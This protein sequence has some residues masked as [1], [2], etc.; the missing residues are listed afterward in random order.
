MDS[1]TGNLPGGGA[2][3][4]LA[5]AVTGRR[6]WSIAL[7]VLV[8]AV[9]IMALV[10][11][12]D[13]AGEAPSALPESAES[14]QVQQRL[15]EFPQSETASAVLVGSRS[16]GAELTSA[17]LTEFD[18]VHTRMLAV[19]E[20]DDGAP[21]PAMV[22]SPDGK[23]V[24]GPVPV[25]AELSGFA[26]SDQVSALR[27]AAST[28]LPDELRAEVTGG[29][30]FGADI[31]DSF[32]GA[33]TTLL[34]VTALVVAA[35]LV[36]TY[37]S[38]ILWLVPLAVI[39]FAD[40]FAGTV[41]TA[42]AEIT[43][44]S[45][46]GSTSGITSVL[47]F[48]AGTNYA[49]LLISRYRQELRSE[50][51]HRLALRHA[52]RQAG[53]TILA[54]NGT[55]VL[56]LLTLLLTSIPSTR[57][58]GALAAAGLLVA[59]VFVLLV[60]PPALALCGKKLFWPF[61]PKVGDPDT[62]SGGTWF[63]VASTVARHPWRTS[64]TA[65]AALG[66]CATG[67]LGIQVG[68]SQTEQF[69]VTAE[70]VDGLDTLAAHFPSGLSNPTTVLVDTGAAQ[71]TASV[72][73]ATPGVSSVTE[74]GRSDTGL[75]RFTVVLDAPPA[76]DEAFATIETIRETLPPPGGTEALVGG[77]DAE[78]LD[79]RNA[80]VRDQLIAVP[81]ILAVVLAVLIVL[82]RAVVAPVVL[83]AT[84][85]LSSLAALGL[86]NGVSTYVFGFPALDDT[87]P[88]FAF[89]FLVALGVDY[90]MF[91]VARAREE[92]P[93]HGTRGGIVRAVAAT[94]GVIT[95]AGIVLAA[96]VT[97][98]GVLPLITLTQLG[99]VVGLGILLDTF[100]VRTLVVPALFTLIGPR[101]WWPSTFDPAP[102]PT[103][104]PAGSGIEA[105]Q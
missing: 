43:G 17:D 69:R 15:A 58:L 42:L 19:G 96:V 20:A 60:L 88:L 9:A 35:L 14:A 63:R 44:L 29:P 74:A 97:V 39:G 18:A 34:A 81:I 56:A 28:G 98:L 102:A 62:T 92:T 93:G 51:D 6:S 55:V 79:Q 70:S 40:R 3:D 85:V 80:A 8:S 86:G 73:A 10:G 64:V 91:L 27:D 21:A 49:L 11:G 5:A 75:T 89:L 16:D 83:V 59:L 66:I 1:S 36:L 57:S 45:F 32:S 37:R 61:V 54:S 24:L 22:P 4:R 71:D 25:D 52:V 103:D 82:L 13:A 87:V 47:V 33:N 72:L 99:I 90:T 31:A 23:A 2:W 41:G 104:S 12:N 76:T 7:A 30:A 53:P 105:R 100:V 26:L 50:D 38:P 94:G 48:G 84:T 78:A 101:V 95:S 67:V 65:V 46:D 68:L 77:S